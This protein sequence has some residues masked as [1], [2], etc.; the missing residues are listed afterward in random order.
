M[1]FQTEYLQLITTR[2]IFILDVLAVS[3][4]KQT[5]TSMLAALQPNP[6][7]LMIGRLIF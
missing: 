6:S 1:E 5:N 3:Q 7:L 2:Y 4:N